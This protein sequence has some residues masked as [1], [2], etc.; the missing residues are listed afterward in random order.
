MSI[1]GRVRLPLRFDAEALAAD[2]ASLPATAWAAHFNTAIYQGDWSGV[3]LRGPAGGHSPLYPD[4]SAEQFDD[5]PLLATSPAMR[6]TLD[7]FECPLTTVRLLRLGPGAT[8]GEHRDHMLRAEDGEARLHI[9]VVT[10][11]GVEFVV[12]GHP[13]EMGAGECWYLDLTLPHRVANRGKAPRV[14]LVVD[15][16]VDGWLAGLLAAPAGVG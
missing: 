1:P 16:Q 8:V 5:A 6:A 10:N 4:P 15:C 3:P 9:P 7:A 12:G 2:V 14:H 11:P 13:V